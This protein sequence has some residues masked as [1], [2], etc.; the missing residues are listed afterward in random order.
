MQSRRNRKVY[1][2]YPDDKHMCPVLLESHEGEASLEVLKAGDVEDYYAFRVEQFLRDGDCDGRFQEQICEILTQSLGN[3]K[4]RLTGLNE[5]T[6]VFLSQIGIPLVSLREVEKFRDQVASTGYGAE[7]LS[8]PVAGGVVLYTGRLE[9]TRI[10][11]NLSGRLTSELLER[12]VEID[13]YVRSV[14]DFSQLRLVPAEQGLEFRLAED[15]KEKSISTLEETGLGRLREEG[16]PL[17]QAEAGLYFLYLKNQ[18]EHGWQA[19]SFEDPRFSHN[20]I[21]GNTIGAIISSPYSDEEVSRPFGGLTSP[22]IELLRRVRGSC[23]DV[24]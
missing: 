23:Q 2:P 16:R 10:A 4:G 3:D 1:K 9:K 12:E 18:N 8:H 24:S 13:S 5:I 22:T 19:S 14:L 15:I 21:R 7:L 17:Y 20:P 11:E 6:G